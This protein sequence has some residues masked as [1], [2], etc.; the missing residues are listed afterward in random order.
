MQW[1]ASTVTMAENVCRQ[2]GGSGAVCACAVPYLENR[3]DARALTRG[4]LQRAM[5]TATKACVSQSNS[6]SSTNS[7]NTGNSGSSGNSGNTGNSGAVPDAGNTGNTGNMGNS[8]NPNSPGSS[9]RP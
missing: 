3:I 9:S 2:G 7:G 4:G 6:G 5:R 8:G 1:P